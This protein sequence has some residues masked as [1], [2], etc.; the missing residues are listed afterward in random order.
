ML[1]LVVSDLLLAGPDSWTQSQ[2]D[3]W[4]EDSTSEEADPVVEGNDM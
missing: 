3:E 2:L 1:Y 4:S